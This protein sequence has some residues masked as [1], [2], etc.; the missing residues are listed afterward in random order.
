MPK[1]KAV[2][3]PLEDG[4]ESTTPKKKSKKEMAKEARAKAKAWH[5]ARNAA[6][7]STT[8]TATTTSPIFSTGTST[9]KSTPATKKKSPK[10]RT[11]PTRKSTGGIKSKSSSSTKASPTRRSRRS[12]GVTSS[13]TKQFEFVPPP[14]KEEAEEE[15]SDDTVPVKLDMS[16]VSSR[17]KK[18]P[19]KSME[20]DNSSSED[21]DDSTTVVAEEVEV[22]KKPSAK[23]A[24]KQDGLAAIQKLKEERERKGLKVTSTSTSAEK[25]MM[26][27]LKSPDPPSNKSSTAAATVHDEQKMSSRPP[28]SGRNGTVQPQPPVNDPGAVRAASARAMSLVAAAKGENV[29]RR[30]SL[31]RAMMGIRD[32]TTAYIGGGNRQ[33]RNVMMTEQQMD[34]VNATLD[35]DEVGGG[36]RQSADPPTTVAAKKT[37]SVAATLQKFRSAKVV[38]S[39]TKQKEHETTTATTVAGENTSEVGEKGGNVKQQQQLADYTDDL[40]EKKPSFVKKLGK[41]CL[42]IG[43]LLMFVTLAVGFIYTVI[44]TLS[45]F[46]DT[47]SLSKTLESDGDVQTS[48]TLPV[49]Q[50]ACFIDYPVQDKVVSDSSDDDDEDDELDDKC[51]GKYKQCPPWGQCEDGKLQNCNDGEGTFDDMVRFIVNEQGNECVI[52]PDAKELTRLVQEALVDMTT[53]QVC[54][55]STSSND[56]EFP[57]FSL[58]L[59]AERVRP[60]DL[61]TEDQEENVDLKP[62]ILIWLRPVFDSKL[63]R[64]GAL[65]GDDEDDVDALGLGDGVLPNSLPLPFGCTAKL[66]AIELLQFFCNSALAVMAFAVNKVW[67][68]LWAYPLYTIGFMVFVRL[69]TWFRQR[70]K[71]ITKIKS[72]RDVVLNLTLDRLSECDNHE[73]WAVLMLRDDVASYL[74]P[75]NW[76]ERQFIID[77]VWP[78]VYVLIQADNR[79]R[80]FRKMAHGRQLE[81]WDFDVQS[82]KMR[83]SL[84]TPR[85]PTP[86]PTSEKNEDISPKQKRDP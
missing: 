6:K 69:V 30:D 8:T 57:L 2:D 83:K 11:T 40:E 9:K 61:S 74:H 67:H 39:V 76:T 19:I 29:L 55:S 26:N 78:S 21:D 53:E 49:E 42:T 71:R 15:E 46:S 85:L 12:V 18:S 13:T 37:S 4:E 54:R 77:Y 41:K 20:V 59:V 14:V 84:S 60:S 51:E 33:Q 5:D 52:S 17:K 45:D 81:H 3:E 58:D 70:R 44:T 65:S 75:T 66:V 79:V 82:K 43:K 63:V 10:K 72:L 27:K 7:S 31:R 1:R 38:A 47:N 32:T 62:D 34:K 56:D 50:D 23:K 80:K 73:G 28:P 16:N 25:K 35:N 68:L 36:R 48:P 64:F 86:L 24:K 22:E